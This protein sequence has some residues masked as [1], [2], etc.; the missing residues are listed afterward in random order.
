MNYGAIKKFD[1][2]DGEGIRVAVYVS[3]CRFNCPGCHNKEAQDFNYGK[4][5]TQD[6]INEI[7]EALDKPFIKGLSVLG[8]EPLAKENREEVSNLITQVKDKFPEK[9]I[10]VWTGYIYENLLKE[11]SAETE[12]NKAP[13]R[14]IFNRIDI[15]IDGPFILSL[16]DISDNNKWR[17]STNQRVLSLK[18][19]RK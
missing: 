5:F 14:N 7:L 11:E 6:T 1:T 10:W 2:S 13:L 16:R 18:A 17:G 8:G 19:L 12:P 15:L 9:D 4:E 3:G